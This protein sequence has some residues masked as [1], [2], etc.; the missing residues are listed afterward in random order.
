LRE[1]IPLNLPPELREEALVLRNRLLLFRCRNLPKPRDL[2]RAADRQ[3]EPRLAQI[4][5]PL[6]ATIEDK[7]A[8]SRLRDLARG[9]ERQLVAD[10]G[11]ET[12]G[13]SSK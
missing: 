8:R 9:Y 3:L 1:D 13:S 5:S 4:L 2:A 6:M 10:R 12:E 11:M 7:E